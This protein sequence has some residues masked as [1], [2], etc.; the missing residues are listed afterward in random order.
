MAFEDGG[1]AT[2]PFC[3]S[4]FL[5]AQAADYSVALAEL[6]AGRKRTHWVWYV[7]PQLCGLGL[8]GASSFYGIAGMDEARAYLAHPVLGERL[9]ECVCAMLANDGKDGREILGEVDAMK[10]RSCL[11]LFSAA[12]PDEPLFRE[13]L[14]RFFAGEP[15]P[16]TMALLG[17]GEGDG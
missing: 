9:R 3:L 14:K 17:A 1:P 6:R 8:S 4:R 7:F 5:D 10:F 16:R 12:A 13:A 2:D 15:D 11:T